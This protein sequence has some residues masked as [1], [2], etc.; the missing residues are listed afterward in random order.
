MRQRA[1]SDGPAFEQDHADWVGRVGVD[2]FPLALGHAVALAREGG[3]VV[4]RDLG[5]FVGLQTR[6]DGQCK[7]DVV[8]RGLAS[9]LYEWV[10]RVR[11]GQGDLV[12]VREVQ[13]VQGENDR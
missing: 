1:E 2:L 8:R 11:L 3:F 13:V 12:C 5:R 7:G 4:L 9:V 6:E 10:V